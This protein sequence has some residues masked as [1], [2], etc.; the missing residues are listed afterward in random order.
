MIHRHG[1][2]ISIHAEQMEVA[3]EAE[4]HCASCASRAACHGSGGQ[5][6]ISVPASAEAQIGQSVDLGMEEATLTR[7]ALLTYLVPPVCLL[8]GAGLGDRFGHG[9]P[10][11]ILGAVAGLAAGLLLVRLLSRLIS[12]ESLEPCVNTSFQPLFPHPGAPRHEHH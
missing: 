3:I 11:A 12:R 10:A 2:I 4:A 8:T 7:T 1:K 6:V 9:D 5:L